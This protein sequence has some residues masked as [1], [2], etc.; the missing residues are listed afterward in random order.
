M[1]KQRS[2]SSRASQRG[3]LAFTTLKTK[4]LALLTAALLLVG[5]IALVSN[6]LL[7]N[8]IDNF[9]HLIEVDNVAVSEVGNL[10]LQFKTQ[11]QEWK[12]VLLRGHNT[13]DREK[14]WGKF[15]EQHEKVQRLFSR[16][17]FLMI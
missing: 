13:E 11:V 12:N 5:L 6:I 14:Y 2:S 17:Q 1:S 4:I 16:Y 10:N 3:S 15:V 7:S 9:K 8:K